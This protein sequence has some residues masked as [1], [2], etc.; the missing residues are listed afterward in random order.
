MWNLINLLTYLLRNHNCHHSLLR[1]VIIATAHQR[2]GPSCVA[3]V[4]LHNGG[5]AFDNA[6]LT[7]ILLAALHIDKAAT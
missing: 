4:L 6:K 5:T 3:T 2:N 1:R 7:S